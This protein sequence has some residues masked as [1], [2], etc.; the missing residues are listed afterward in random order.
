MSTC[1]N[2]M[3]SISNY[4]HNGFQDILFTSEQA[5]TQWAK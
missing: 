4:G 1:Y 5:P 3:A 2:T